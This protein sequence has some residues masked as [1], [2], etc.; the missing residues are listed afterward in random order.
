MYTHCPFSHSRVVTDKSKEYNKAKSFCSFQMIWNF[1]LKKLRKIIPHIYFEELCLDFFFIDIE[2]STLPHRWFLNDSN[3]FQYTLATLQTLA[4]GMQNQWP[5]CNFWKEDTYYVRLKS[6]M[7]TTTLFDCQDR[8]CLKKDPKWCRNPG[9]H[10]V[11][12]Y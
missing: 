7:F 5:A 8:H 12:W 6:I 3:I 1:V 10:V 2:K 9:L 4:A 11:V